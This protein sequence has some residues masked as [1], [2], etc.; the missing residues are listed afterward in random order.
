MKFFSKYIFSA[1]YTSHTSLR[2]VFT[3]C[4]AVSFFF[5]HDLLHNGDLQLIIIIIIIII[6]MI[7]VITRLAINSNDLVNIVKNINIYSF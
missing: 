6:K 1:L 2:I 4:G 5:S 3:F 7:I